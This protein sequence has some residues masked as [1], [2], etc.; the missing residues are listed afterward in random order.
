VDF[1]VLLDDSCPELV[2]EE[3]EEE[4]GDGVKDEV[5]HSLLE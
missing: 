2:E 4:S 5:E 3:A 1:P